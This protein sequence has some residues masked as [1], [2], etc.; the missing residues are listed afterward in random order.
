MNPTLHTAANGHLTM[1]L[2]GLSDAD[3]LSLAEDLVQHQGFNRAGSPAMGL[4]EHI[5]PS[6]QCAEFSLAAGWDI[7]SGHYLLS[8]SVAGDVFLQ[9]LFNQRQS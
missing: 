1:N 2:D 8:D 9:K 7:W 5:H 6:F 4:S 3:W